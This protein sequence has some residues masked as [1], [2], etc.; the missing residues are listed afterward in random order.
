MPINVGTAVTEHIAD[1]T[2]VKQALWAYGHLGTHESALAV[3]QCVLKEYAR[4]FSSITPQ[5]P[6]QPWGRKP[7]LEPCQ[8]PPQVE[9]PARRAKAVELREAARN[10]Y[11]M[12]AEDGRQESVAL[13]RFAKAVFDVCD[14]LEYPK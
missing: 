7:Q 2:D 10:M 8:A 4:S 11:A 1:A 5:Q 6:A 3:V 12:L 13:R 9:T 14:L